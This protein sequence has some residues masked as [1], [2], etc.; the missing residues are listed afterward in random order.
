VTYS[1]EY[2]AREAARF[3]HYQWQEFIALD[4]E[5]QSDTVAHY[6]AHGQIEGVMRN[7]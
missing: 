2:E 4:G 1:G 7:A 3:S 5:E 6:L